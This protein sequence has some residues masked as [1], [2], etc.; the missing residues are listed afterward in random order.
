MN[1]GLSK[2][3]GQRIAFVGVENWGFGGFKK[4]GDLDLAGKGLSPEKFKILLSHDPSYWQE[5]IKS[6]ANNYQLTLSGHTHFIQFGIEIP[7]W[8]KYSPIQYRKRIGREF[9]RN[10]EDISM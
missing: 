1:T 4:L 6:D 7:G 8:F 9:M 5:K 3:S 10:L 2:K